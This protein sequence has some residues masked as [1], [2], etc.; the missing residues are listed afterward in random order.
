[1]PEFNLKTLWLRI[2]ARS[3]TDLLFCFYHSLVIV[4]KALLSIVS[5]PFVTFLIYGIQ[6]LYGAL[7]G[8]QLS[9]QLADIPTDA[10]VLHWPVLF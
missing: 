3:F 6:L 9:S 7:L 2:Q 8:A 10:G 4:L 1:M 5:H